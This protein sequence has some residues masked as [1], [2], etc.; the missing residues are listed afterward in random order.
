[1]QK[2]EDKNVLYQSDEA[3]LIN[4]YYG[5]PG[6]KLCKIRPIQADSGNYVESN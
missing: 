2:I 5:I 4:I 6:N 3:A 1:M